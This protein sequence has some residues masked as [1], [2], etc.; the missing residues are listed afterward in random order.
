MKLRVG[1]VGLGDAWETRHRPALRALSD[2]FDIKAIC[3]EVAHLASQA[4]RDFQ[5]EAVD[6]YRSLCARQDIDAILML[7]AEWYGPLPILAACEFGALRKCQISRIIL[8]VIA[9]SAIL[10]IGQ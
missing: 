6:G 5:A 7:S 8:T 2:R 9:E 3:C 1:I 10:K 4:A